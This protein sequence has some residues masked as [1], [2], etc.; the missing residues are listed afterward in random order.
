MHILD[1]KDPKSWFPRAV[2]AMR[3]Y[4]DQHQLTRL[5]R[6]EALECLISVIANEF[7]YVR[8]YHACR[9]VDVSSYY[10]RGIIRHNDWLLDRAREFF[11]SFPEIPSDAVER[12]IVMTDLTSDHGRVFVVLDDRIFLTEA[13]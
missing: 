1:W 11:R 13:G 9:P 10:E 12:A 6:D 4:R 3:A 8:V 7:T 5:P 2:S